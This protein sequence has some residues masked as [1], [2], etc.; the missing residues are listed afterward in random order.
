MMTDFWEEVNKS[1]GMQTG[2]KCS[3][4]ASVNLEGDMSKRTLGL[5][6]VG[7][8]L[9]TLALAGCGGG[10]NSGNS[11]TT[12]NGRLQ[13]GDQTLPTDTYVQAG[14]YVDVYSCVARDNGTAQVDLKSSD[15]DSFLIVGTEDGSG[16]YVQTIATDDNS[17]DGQ[18]ARVKFGINRDVRYFVAATNADGSGRTGGYEM[19]FSDSL[20]DVVEETQIR[21]AVLAAAAH[22]LSA[23][24]A[25]KK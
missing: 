18:N 17:G 2:K 25:Q 20:K 15:F 13:S 11:Q 23:Y 24:R 7:M 6:G 4:S 21:P 16:R 22:A 14:S 8:A 3:L 10:G 9:T 12:I 1:G 5:L 19:K